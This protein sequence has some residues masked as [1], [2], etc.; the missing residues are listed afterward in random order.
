MSVHKVER[1]LLNMPDDKHNP[2]R[3]D[4][5]ITN[6]EDNF[7]DENVVGRAYVKA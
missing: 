6:T 5:F 4:S 2:N 1:G 7:N 3:T